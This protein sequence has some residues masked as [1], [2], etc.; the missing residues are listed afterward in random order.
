MAQTPGTHHKHRQN[1]AKPLRAG[2]ATR[3]FECLECGV[4]GMAR[5]G[6]CGDKCGLKNDMFLIYI[7]YIYVLNDI[8]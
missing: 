6:S 8:K 4:Y 3:R 1:L 7:I 2:T 5:V